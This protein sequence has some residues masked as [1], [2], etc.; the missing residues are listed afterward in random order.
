MVG[1]TIDALGGGVRAYTAD[2][3]WHSWF[4]KALEAGMGFRYVRGVVAY[5]A[6]LG[7]GLGS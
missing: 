7:V 1:A 6:A 2:L 3:L 4:C 5:T